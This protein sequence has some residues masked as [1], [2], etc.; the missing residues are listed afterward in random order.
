MAKQRHVHLSVG[1]VKQFWT[2]SNTT[3]QTVDR[4]WTGKQNE[5]Q[6]FKHHYVLKF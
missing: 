2:G 1:Q 4:W 3:G 5:E 6:V